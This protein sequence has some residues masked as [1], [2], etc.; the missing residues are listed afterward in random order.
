MRRSIVDIA[1]KAAVVTATAGFMVVWSA[2]GAQAAEGS[3]AGA[4]AEVIP[5]GVLMICDTQADGNGAYVKVER[6][7]G[8]EINFWDGTGADNVCGGPFGVATTR[9]QVCEDHTGCS[10]WIKT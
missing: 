7:D 1:R 8:L 4:Y 5:E 9:F 6:T 10:G 3:F 2:T